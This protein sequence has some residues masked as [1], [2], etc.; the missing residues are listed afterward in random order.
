MSP[1]NQK[2]ALWVQSAAGYSPNLMPALRSVLLRA[3]AV[4]ERALRRLMPS[5]MNVVPYSWPLLKEECPC[6]VHFC[7]YL[8]E[9]SIANSAIFHFG[10]GGHH[11][12]GLRNREDALDNEILAI[13]ASPREHARY[14]R[15]LIRDS[16]LGKHYRVLFADIYDLSGRSLPEFDVITL[17]HLCE[18]SPTVEQHRRMDDAGVLDLFLS[19]LTP[20]GRLLFYGESFGRARTRLI[21]ERAVADGK[22]S[23]EEQYQSLLIYRV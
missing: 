4:K 5:R 20:R 2:F 21:T 22:M 7:D 14:V 23:F 17:F 9:H 10:S 11:L 18:F 6:D 16:S 15:L 12:V 8:R 13:T 19:K 3:G 1:A